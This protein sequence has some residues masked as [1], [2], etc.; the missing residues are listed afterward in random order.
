[1]K[2]KFNQ[3]TKESQNF[4]ILREEKKI[5]EKYKPNKKDNSR[6]LKIKVLKNL[7]EERKLSE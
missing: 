2:F 4:F 6:V 3:V 7:Q 5:I 1:M